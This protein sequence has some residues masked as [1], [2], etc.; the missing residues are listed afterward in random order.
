MRLGSAD[1]PRIKRGK[2]IG[3]HQ[4]AHVKIECYR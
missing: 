3:R 2:V 1:V 4:A